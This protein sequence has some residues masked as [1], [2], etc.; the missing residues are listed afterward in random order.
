MAF[1]RS[2]LAAAAAQASSPSGSLWGTWRAWVM[3]AVLGMLLSWVQA[4]RA[5]RVPVPVSVQV[6]LLAKVAEYD[7]NLVARAGE[8]VR[9]V[10]LSKPEDAQSERALAQ[11]SAAF[12]DVE[13]IADLPVE[14][15]SVAFTDA[16][17]L[18]RLCSAR[19]VAIVY[20]TPGFASEVAAIRAALDGVDV[21]SVSSVPEYVEK[22][23]V[24]GFDLASGKPKL[25]VHLEQAKLQN[26]SFRASA[27]KLMRILP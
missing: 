20:L 4:A 12:A 23:I 3:A 16:A 27:L 10:L 24:L 17:A 15:S 14:V 7:K 11:M 18:R 6:G 8:I 9:V 25:L 2:P 21:L 19:H 5:E 1:R 26:V 13:R 22:G